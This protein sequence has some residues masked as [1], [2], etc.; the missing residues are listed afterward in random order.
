MAPWTTVDA[1][2]V[3]VSYAPDHEADCRDAAYRSI[4]TVLHC[5][6]HIA[7]EDEVAVP[8]MRPHLPSC[9]IVEAFPKGVFTATQLNSTE[10]N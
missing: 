2:D 3:T 1:F 5:T 8:K 6:L 9:L 4:Y 10:L 7:H